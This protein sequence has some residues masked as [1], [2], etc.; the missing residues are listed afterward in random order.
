MA[1]ATKAHVLDCGAMH[2]DKAI[3]A[4]SPAD[5]ATRHDRQRPAVWHRAPCHAVLVEHDEGLLLF[6]TSPPRD[7]EERWAESGLND[8]LPYD[9]VSEE[10]YLDARLEQLGVAPADIDTVVL[11]HLHLDHV[12]NARMFEP[13]GARFLVHRDELERATSFEG[14]YDIGYFKVDYEGLPWETLTGDVELYP[15]ITL[16]EVPGHTPGTMAMR[17]DLPES[18]TVIFTSDAVDSAENYGPP[19]VGSAIN[20]CNAQAARSIERIRAL[21]E[22]DRRAARLQPRPGP[23]PAPPPGAAGRL[24]VI[25]PRVA[26]LDPDAV[27]DALAAD[28]EFVLAA[29]DWTVRLELWMG[30]VG[31]RVEVERGRVVR[32]LPRPS[33]F[34][35]AD[36]VLSADSETWEEIL[37]PVPRPFYLDVFSAAVHHGLSMTG[38]LE[39]LYAYHPAVRRMLDVM[40]A[41]PAAAP[42]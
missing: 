21:A 2:G 17:V 24:H 41:S 7:W 30:E 3:W 8:L 1:N 13:G 12:G 36:L 28:P 20:Y 16:L 14:P 37:A 27:R 32:V 18:G 39:S 25:G 42:V 23:D 34:E 40:R 4:A 5:L 6:D 38:D 19:P 15:G 26:S 9:D 35:P 31:W 33:M 22:P 10:Q 11:S 29:R